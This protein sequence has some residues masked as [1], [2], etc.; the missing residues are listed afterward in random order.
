MSESEWINLV[1][2]F[3]RLESEILKGALEA[4]GIPCKLVQE[5]VSHYIY[6]VNGPMGRIQVCVPSEKMEEAQQW[7][8]AYNQ[9]ELQNDNY[10]LTDPQNDQ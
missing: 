9:G 4:Q 3:D 6:P 1:D 8:E 5:G 10:D 7:L 2:V